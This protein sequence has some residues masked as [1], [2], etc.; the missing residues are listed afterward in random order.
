MAKPMNEKDE[1]KGITS[2]GLQEILDITCA[3]LEFYK[4]W[5]EVKKT[6]KNYLII[7]LEEVLESFTDSVDDLFKIE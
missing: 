3:C 5:L 4:S 7:S 6:Y 1:I 2:M